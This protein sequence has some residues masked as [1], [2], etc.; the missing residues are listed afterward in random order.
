MLFCSQRL[1]TTRCCLTCWGAV[2]NKQYR[3]WNYVANTADQYNQSYRCC[4]GAFNASNSFCSPSVPNSWKAWLE[5]WTLPQC[6]WAQFKALFDVFIIKMFKKAIFPDIDTRL[7]NYTYSH[8]ACSRCC[9]R[10]LLGRAPPPL[11]ST[12]CYTRVWAPACR[13]RS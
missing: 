12:P 13:S 10:D 1:S 8:R 5:I 4:D 6:P 11:R 3:A 7:I 9:L 2:D